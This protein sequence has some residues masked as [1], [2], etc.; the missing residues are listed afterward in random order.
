MAWRDDKLTFLNI[1]DTADFNSSA[2]REVSL[3]KQSKLW[4]PL[5][6]IVHENAVIGEIHAGLNRFV[7][8][9]ANT[10]PLIPN[11]RSSVEDVQYSG[12]DNFLMMGGDFKISY[13]C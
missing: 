8:V 7:R 11:T 3:S 2:S 5:E 9:I 10:N 4:L 1:R 13:K 12:K 6:K